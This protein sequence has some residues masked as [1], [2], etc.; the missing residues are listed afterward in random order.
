M[1][2]TIIY[3]LLLSL[4]QQPVIAQTKPTLPFNFFDVFNYSL[5][6]SFNYNDSAALVAEIKKMAIIELNFQ[7]MDIYIKKIS[8]GSKL[9]LIFQSI[10]NPW[11]QKNNGFGGDVS[12]ESTTVPRIIEARTLMGGKYASKIVLPNTKIK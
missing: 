3:I 8:K 2:K 11:H 10:N 9:R 6:N 1:Q 4:I 12:K 7:N 5:P